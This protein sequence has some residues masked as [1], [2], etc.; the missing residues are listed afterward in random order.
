MK[1]EQEKRYA[2]LLAA[3]DSDYVEKM[4]NGYFNV[5]VQAFGEEGENWEL[6]RVVE[7]EFPDMENLDEYDGFVISGSPHDA[8]GND[9]WI[10]RLCFLLQTLH[11][12]H[13]KVLGI[14]FGHQV[15]CRALGGRVA[16]AGGGWDVGIRK[17]VMVDDDLPRPKL[18]DRLGEIPTSA[19]IV[20][21]H[22][23]EVWQ[24]P[25]GAEVIGFSEKTGVE[26][27]CVGD[28]ILG[29]QGHPEYGKDILYNLMDRLVSSYSINRCF[30]DDV[31]ASLEETEPDKKFWEKLCKTFLKGNNNEICCA[32]KVD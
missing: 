27:F 32:V 4:Y 21:C 8:Y 25:V 23:D 28:H 18:F 10:L 26:M 31:K 7:G 13:K 22:Q 14:C 12:M 11:A 29:I 30:A 6:F 3:R 15:I 17:V 1:I 9:L 16:K 19:L 5:F 20:E 24:V 2:L